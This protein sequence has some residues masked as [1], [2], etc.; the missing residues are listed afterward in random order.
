M[1]FS[2]ASL[3]AQML[4]IGNE[5]GFVQ[6]INIPWRYYG[7]DFGGRHNRQ[8][9]PSFYDRMFAKVAASGV[10]CVRMW[11][12]CDGRQSPRLGSNGSIERLGDQ[13]LA[14]IGDF[15]DRAAEHDL[16]VL[17]VLWTF[18]MADGRLS[19]LLTDE[20][21]QQS[22]IT[23]SLIP[24]L[25]HTK[26][27]CNILAWEIINEPEW[28]MDIPFAGTT[29][30]T[31]P[32]VAMQQFVG[33]IAEAVHRH[34]PHRVTV[35]SAGL[36]F[37]TDVFAQTKNYWHDL[38][39]QRA[40]LTC[41]T[42]TL[43]FYSVHYYRWRFENLS[44]FRHSTEELQLD[45]PV[46]IGE[47]GVLEEPAGTLLEKALIN[48]YAGAMAWSLLANDGFGSWSDYEGDMNVF[49]REKAPFMP[50]SNRCMSDAEPP[51]TSCL[52]YPNPAGSAVSI[53]VAHSSAILLSMVDLAGRLII[54][55]KEIEPERYLLDLSGYVSGIYHIIL[56]RPNGQLLS[57]QR[58]AVL[59]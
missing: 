21:M 42:A 28:A 2:H 47:F 1:L 19:D 37:N 11:I 32:A 15:I 14:D 58:L 30:H 5:E 25:Q 45:K 54:D 55:R 40:G 26:D 39:F 53:S 7:Q 57:R 20:A 46:L 10:N 17:P 52:L 33:R 4:K 24:L 51:M 9:D 27:K 34:S 16:L 3:P 59:D 6:G 36:R 29:K 44:P 22:Y 35:G 50:P 12:H 23:E 13:F 43:D 49:S 41:G 8:Y 18:E 38:A 31:V 48:G 56:Q